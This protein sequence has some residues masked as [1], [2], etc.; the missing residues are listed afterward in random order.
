MSWD[1]GNIVSVVGARD[2]E[3]MQLL[4][5]MLPEEEMCKI[6]ALFEFPSIPKLP[7]GVSY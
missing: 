7:C 4:P 3:E 6:H 1:H 2:V 5:D